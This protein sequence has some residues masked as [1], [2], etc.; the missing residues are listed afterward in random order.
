M[1]GF[2]K[3]WSTLWKRLGQR[4][5]R[6][7]II[8]SCILVVLL[9]DKLVITPYNLSL[10]QMDQELIYRHKQKVWYQRTLAQSTKIEKAF[11]T[12]EP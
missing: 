6:L 1:S 5:Q 3:I 11:A 2:N 7:C 9:V 4:E 12:Y 8:A 10:Q